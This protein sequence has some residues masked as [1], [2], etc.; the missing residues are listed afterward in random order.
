MHQEIEAHGCILYSMSDAA[1][2]FA[3]MSIPCLSAG[4]GTGVLGIAMGGLGAKVTI[5]DL[6]DE[7]Q[8]IESNIERNNELWANSSA[9]RPTVREHAWGLDLD[10]LR[11]H[12]FDYVVGADLLYFG[13][14]D[15]MSLDTREPL[16]QSLTA[17]VSTN[18][19]AVLVWV[20]RH[21]NREADFVHRAESLFRTRVHVA[22]NTSDGRLTWS[23]ICRSPLYLCDTEGVQITSGPVGPFLEGTPVCLQLWQR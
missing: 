21:P 2:T 11:S 3:T 15:L 20:V 14:W 22:S 12:H 5:T 18:S 7:V 13:G 23:E 4:G 8:H 6:R 17:A 9:H 19:E 10:W 16:L 1:P